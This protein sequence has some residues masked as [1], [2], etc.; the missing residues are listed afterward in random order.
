MNKTLTFFIITFILFISSCINIPND[1]VYIYVVN[2]TQESIWVTN[3]PMDI[4]SGSGNTTSVEK[5]SK[6][7]VKGVDSKYKYGSRTFQVDSQWDVY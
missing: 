1:P 3:L 4:P 5:G 2:H 7:D 6:V